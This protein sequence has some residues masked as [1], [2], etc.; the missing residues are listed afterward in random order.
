MSA[1]VAA[2]PLDSFLTP[3]G[4]PRMSATVA[5]LSLDSFPRREAPLA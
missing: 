5:T 2:L 1:A 3:R 4:A